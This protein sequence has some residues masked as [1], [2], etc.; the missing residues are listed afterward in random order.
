MLEFTFQSGLAIIYTDNTNPETEE[1][2]CQKKS[3]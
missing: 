2:K 1:M 3:R